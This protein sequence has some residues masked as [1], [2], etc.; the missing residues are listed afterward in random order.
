M[1]ENDVKQTHRNYCLRAQTC[2]KVNA[3]EMQ[4]DNY[5]LTTTLSLR[6]QG[7]GGWL[8]EN[9]AWGNAGK[10]PPFPPLLT[11]IDD[12]LRLRRRMGAFPVPSPSCMDVSIRSIRPRSLGGARALR[13]HPNSWTA[14]STKQIPPDNLCLLPNHL[15]VGSSKTYSSG[16]IPKLLSIVQ[17][18]SSIVPF[19]SS[20]NQ[21]SHMKATLI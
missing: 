10:L 18:P 5:L 13:T 8:D 16:G 2:A 14:A 12:L 17:L 11:S 7:K 6:K 19:R 1:G 9:P 15:L 3:C 21:R 4:T 20:H